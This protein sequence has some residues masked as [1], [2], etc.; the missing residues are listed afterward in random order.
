MASSSPPTPTRQIIQ[1]EVTKIIE[2][3]KTIKVWSN[4][5]WAT[6]NAWADGLNSNGITG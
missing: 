1:V 2:V 4:M 3:I 6:A 5:D